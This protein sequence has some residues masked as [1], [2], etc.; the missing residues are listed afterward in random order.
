MVIGSLITIIG[1]SLILTAARWLGGGN[2]A[3]S[4]FGSFPSLSLDLA[5]IVIT[6]IIHARAAG[7]AVF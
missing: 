6:L 5:T 4:D 1:I 3:A 7:I 2:P